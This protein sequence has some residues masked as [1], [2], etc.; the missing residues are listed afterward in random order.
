MKL[1]ETSREVSGIIPKIKITKL[2]IPS[3]KSMERDDNVK[4]KLHFAL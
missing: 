2:T 1:L 4:V 3:R